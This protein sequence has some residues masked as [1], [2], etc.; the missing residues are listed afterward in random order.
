MFLDEAT[1]TV[2]GGGGGRGCVS[3]RREKF[4]PMGGP[5][6]GN[7]GKGGDVVLKADENADT[8]SD[9]VSRKRFEAEKGRFG[10]GRNRSGKGGEDMIL[11]VPPGTLTYDV[12]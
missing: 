2:R 11:P 6:G 5:D 8:L 9:Y 7:G 10:S 4:E 1:I 12:T 3:W